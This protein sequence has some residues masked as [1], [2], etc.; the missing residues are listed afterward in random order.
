[1]GS[2]ELLVKLSNEIYSTCDLFAPRQLSG[3]TGGG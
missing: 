3:E 2:P 1:M